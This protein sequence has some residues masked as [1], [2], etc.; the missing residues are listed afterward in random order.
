MSDL[1]DRLRAL[2]LHASAP[3][4][5]VHAELLGDTEITVYLS[6]GF[7]RE[8]TE[9]EIARRLEQLGKLLWAQRMRAYREVAEV[10]GGGLLL[11]DPDPDV[12][13]RDARFVDERGSLVA[14]GFSPD[15]HVTIEVR[16]MSEW[17]VSLTPGTLRM[18]DEAT[19][20]RAVEIAA[21]RMIN[22]QFMKTLQL[23]AQVYGDPA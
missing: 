19:F 11:A 9:T 20:T 12:D 3:S 23:K 6:T 18:L 15:G 2:H 4:G 5:G 16:G 21:A 1:I 13:R 17:T 22:D 14:Q 10:P 7:Y 8:T